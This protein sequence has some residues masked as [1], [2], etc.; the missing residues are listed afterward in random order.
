MNRIPLLGLI[1]LA[2][3]IRASGQRSDTTPGRP[4]LAAAVMSVPAIGSQVKVRLSDR[5]AIEGRYR[6]ASLDTLVLKTRDGN[7]GVAL[8]TIDSL[9]ESRSLMLR[10]AVQGALIG[11]AAGLLIEALPRLGGCETDQCLTSSVRQPVMVGVLTGAALGALLGE[12]RRDW[13][14]LYPLRNQP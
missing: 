2:L 13:R 10:T 9:W 8:S 14:L 5:D 6:S 12:M 7:R 11:V 4:A 1:V 3:P